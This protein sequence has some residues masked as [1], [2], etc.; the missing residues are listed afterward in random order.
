MK[1]NSRIL[2]SGLCA[3][4][5]AFGGSVAAS[6][7][8][9]YAAEVPVASDSPDE[10]NTALGSAML[11]VLVRLSGRADVA[12]QRAAASV[13][14]RAP[15]LVQQFRYRVDE[16]LPGTDGRAQSS[17]QRYLWAKFDKVALDRLLRES[18][19]PVW[20]ARRPQV[21]LWL[22]VERGSSRNLLNPENDLE[23]RA[24]LL[25]KAYQRGMPL[26]LPLMDLQDQAA[27][28]A[29]D[30]WAGYEAALREASARYPHDVILGGRLRA[31]GPDR[32]SAEWTLWDRD[33]QDSYSTG[34][35]SWAATLAAGLDGAQ[36]RLAIRYAPAAGGDGPD[37]VRVRFTGVDSLPAYGR[38]LEIL[39]GR[40]AI[41]RINL[42]A[43]QDDTL[44]M[45]IW[46]RGGR[47]A[48]ARML[49][50]GGEFFLQPDADPGAGPGGGGPTGGVETPLEAPVDMT[51]SFLPSLAGVDQAR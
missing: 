19:I 3:L 16:G 40:E 23:T 36:D 7:G 48:L 49:S 11:Q 39:Q 8:D 24:L 18:D 50:L 37:R 26:Q 29:A 34:G 28:S 45:D 30:L 4:L 47:N 51:F 27:L 5:L 46:V 12:G 41:T 38:L 20:G 44:R 17:P 2:L 33:E 25:D 35:L 10:R 21:L 22:A 13:M 15:S 6:L 43:A 31:L 42:R 9:L 1:P 14:Q 32:W